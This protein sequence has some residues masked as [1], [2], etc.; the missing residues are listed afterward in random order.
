MSRALEMSY[1]IQEIYIWA[2]HETRVVCSNNWGADGILRCVSD[3]TKDQ[4]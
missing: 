3:G 4:C 1:V 2:G